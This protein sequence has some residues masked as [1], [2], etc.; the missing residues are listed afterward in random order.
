M[1]RNLRDLFQI[2]ISLSDVEPAVWRRLLLSSSTDLAEL[3]QIIQI[4][5]GWSNSHLHQFTANHQQYGVPDT[6]FG[7]SIAPERGKRIGSF[8]KHENQWITYEY[9]SG[10]C[11]EHVITLERILPYH[12]GEAGP[13]C[14]DGRRACPPED[15]GGAWE[16]REFLEAYTDSEHPDHQ[17]KVDWLGEYFDPEQFDIADVNRKLSA[18]RKTKA[19]V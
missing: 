17:E 13:S 16:Y 3:H 10:D 8:L 1:Q 15:I 19:A 9:D 18:L 14:I 2:R 6:E 7:D 12:P 11:W 5:M 4:A